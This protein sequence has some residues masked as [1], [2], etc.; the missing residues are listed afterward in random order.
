MQAVASLVE[1]FG[2][3]DVPWQEV[4]RLVR[5]SVDVGMGGGPD[6]VHAVYGQLQEDGRL[7][8]F[9]GDS[10]VMLVQWDADGRLTSQSIHQFGSATSHPESPHYAD[11]A[12]LFAN[13]QLKPVWLTEAE[14]RAHL[15][16]EYS[17]GE[18]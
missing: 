5:G 18:E 3:V 9:V 4:N 11:Q 17:P 8:G 14:I 16:R 13:R 1:H 6:I 15:E 2:R 10:Y 7:H 12:P